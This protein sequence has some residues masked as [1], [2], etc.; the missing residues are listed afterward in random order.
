MRKEI[1]NLIILVALLSISYFLYKQNT[2]I[3]EL[4]SNN[5][6][7]M[8]EINCLKEIKNIVIPPVLEE[9]IVSSNNKLIVAGAIVVATVAVFSMYK[10][11]N[12]RIIC[13]NTLIYA[14]QQLNIIKSEH[15]YEMKY[16]NLIYKIITKDE[17]LVNVFV[18]TIHSGN[19]VQVDTYIEDLKAST[20]SNMTNSNIES[21]S[22]II[23]SI[24][25]Y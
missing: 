23:D 9:E 25:V 6:L 15:I 14:L 18:K 5:S 2:V 17:E 10:S 3:N 24:N 13:T 19:F 1:N 7:L 8:N 21:I 16:G 4:Q 22:S 11:S 12:Y 20:I